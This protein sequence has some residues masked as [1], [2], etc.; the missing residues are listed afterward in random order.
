MDN[1]R[2]PEELLGNFEKETAKSVRLSDIDE[3]GRIVNTRYYVGVT[4]T[5]K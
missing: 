5:K 1:L 2:I 3:E 4:G